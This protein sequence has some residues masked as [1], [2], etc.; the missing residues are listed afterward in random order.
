MIDVATASLE[1]IQARILA[2]ENLSAAEYRTVLDRY[3]ADRKSA[4]ERS[5]ASRAK[6]A[7]AAQA[8][9]FDLMAEIN[10]AMGKVK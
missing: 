5:T 1:E 4:S 3:R 6:K 8:G 2:G 10:E 7:T 9:N